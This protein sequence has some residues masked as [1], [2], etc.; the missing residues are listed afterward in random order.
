MHVKINWSNGG[1]AFGCM[2]KLEMITVDDLGEPVC[3]CMR[4]VSEIAILTV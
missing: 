1:V 2:K 3:A 4:Q